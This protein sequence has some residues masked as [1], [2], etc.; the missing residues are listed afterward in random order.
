MKLKDFI[1]LGTY[2][3]IFLAG[4]RAGQKHSGQL[5]LNGGI[6][7]TRTLSSYICC[8]VISLAIKKHIGD[9]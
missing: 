5:I 3:R 4:E 8:N 6:R 2:K 7:R 1:L 9:K